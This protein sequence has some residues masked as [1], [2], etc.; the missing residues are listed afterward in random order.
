MTEEKLFVSAG[1]CASQSVLSLSNLATVY[2]YREDYQKAEEIILRSYDIYDGYPRANNNL[3]LIYWKTGR[4]EE[5]KEQYLKTFE[6]YPPYE[7]VYENLVLFYLSRG[8]EK[9][10]KKWAKI[11]EIR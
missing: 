8:N 5:A 2:Y 9:E 1:K 6:N 4:S 7:G 3:G 11:G 10:A